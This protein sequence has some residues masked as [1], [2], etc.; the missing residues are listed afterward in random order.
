M[1]C[2]LFRKSVQQGRSE[3]RGE[4]LPTA[5]RGAFR[6]YNDLG[7]WKNPTCISDFR[8]SQSDVEPLN[9]ARMPLAGLYQQPA[10]KL[11]DIFQ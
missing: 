7:E 2:R 4:E 3:R 5:L 1:T 9:D 6:T 11:S 8:E 10:K